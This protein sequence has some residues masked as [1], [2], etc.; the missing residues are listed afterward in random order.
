M[1]IR[2]LL[3]PP[4]V[5]ARHY[6]RTMIFSPDDDYSQPSVELID[7]SLRA[8]KRAIDIELKNVSSRMNKPPYWP[9]NWPG[10]HYRLLA[11]FVSELQPK[12]VI[13]IGTSTGLSALSMKRY[14]PI[15]SQIV[16]FDLI[17]WENFE[18]TV[19]TS[20]DFDNG[21]LK[22]V[23]GDVANPDIMRSHI[24]LFRD[25]DFIFVDGPKD[26]VFEPLFLENLRMV[27]FVSAP[28]LI[29]DDI[30]D[31]NMLAFWRKISKPKLD[32]TSFGHWTGTGL[33][34]W[35]PEKHT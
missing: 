22:Q 10:E 5:S 27:D 35:I 19:L 1:K 20:E 11:A 28:Y 16:T 2:S 25:A 4:P 15:D 6:K 24:D 29:F 26:G 31:W 7:L 33:V 14:L 23:I 13:E 9:D 30:K 34:H 8:I 17:K 18:D 3:F 12:K 21:R 32:L